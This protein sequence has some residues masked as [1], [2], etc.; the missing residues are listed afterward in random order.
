MGF[1]FGQPWMLL[2]LMILVP[3]YYFYRYHLKQKKEKA[4][5]FSSL[6]TIKRI[7]N[8]PRFRPHVPFFLFSLALTMM[9]LGMADPRIPWKTAKEGVNVV[10]VIDDSGSMAA[11]DYEPTRL[12][13]AKGAAEL[14]IKDLKANDNVGIVIFESGATTAAYLTPFKDRA[15]EKLKAVQQREGATALGDGLA[16][17]IDMANSIPN[18]RRV[19]ILLS[20]GVANAG[21]ISPQEATELARDENIQVYTIGLGSI[22]PTVI[23]YDLF[24][25]AQY[26]E[27]DET[28]LK[29]IASDTRGNYYKSVDEDTLEEIYRNIG[30][31]LEREWEDTPIKD[32]F[33]L[34]AIIFLLANIYVVY[35]KYRIIM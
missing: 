15:L 6:K 1:Y 16:M 8:V 9:I 4:V 23:G 29:N 35:G 25:R 10:L 26:A 2:G 5:T 31:N 11:T 20:D 19:V 21:V 32:W 3:L 30:E 28:T 12:E 33:F 27:L 7:S 18:K 17:G 22:E 13:A 24:G 14:L 34:A